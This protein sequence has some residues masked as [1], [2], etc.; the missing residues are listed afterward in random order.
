MKRRLGLHGIVEVQPDLFD[1]RNP[2]VLSSPNYPGERLM[3][4]RNPELAKL[5]A[6]KREALLCTTERTLEKITARVDAGRRTGKDEIGV[7][8]GKV[9]NQYKVAK[10][11]ALTI[12]DTSFT[13]EGRAQGWPCNH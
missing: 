2:F 5:R 1:E 10:H 11:V 13:Y 3:A 4:C 7:R 6:H 9:V 12:G 8:V